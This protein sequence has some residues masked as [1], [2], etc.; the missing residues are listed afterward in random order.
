MENHCTLSKYLL[1]L[2]IVIK[3]DPL[4]KEKHTIKNVTEELAIENEIF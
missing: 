4:S 3:V 2:D 1:L